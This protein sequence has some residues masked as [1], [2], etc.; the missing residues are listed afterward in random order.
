MQ[1]TACGVRGI[2]V[3]PHALA[4]QSAIA[5]LREGGNALEAMIAAAATIAVVYPHMNGIGGDAFWLLSA[6]GA[7]VRAIDASGAAGRSVSRALY[8]DH[9]LDTIPMR[10]PLASNTVAGTISGWNKAL[11]IGAEWGG[12][13]PLSRLLGD[14]IHYARDGI[15]VTASQAAS[16]QAKLAELATQPGF[17]ETFLID[18]A[19][20]Q[21][22]SVFLQPRLAEVLE[23]L[24]RAGLD[25]YY[26]GDL[27]RRIAGDLATIGSPLTLEDLNAHRALEVRP[28]AL[29]HSLGTVYN[30]T[31]P[32]QGV[33][34]LAILGVADRLGLDKLD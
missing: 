1:N 4:A 33:I 10:G 5:V 11:E 29:R 3:A 30:M 14:A 23:Q 19:S 25:D 2:A 24:V 34:S 16:T 13:L 6:P 26:R 12:R 22:G 20:P 27:A 7:P 21:A 9:G 17:A 32:T 31:P 15:P 8:A 18:G 28:L